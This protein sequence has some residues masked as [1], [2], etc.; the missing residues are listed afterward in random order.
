VGVAVVAADLAA[1]EVVA[2]GSAAASVVLE[3]TVDVVE[4]MAGLAT[5]LEEGD[6]VAAT[7]AVLED[8]SPIEHDH[9]FDS[10]ARRVC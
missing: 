7:E 1:H 10:G 5:C 8:S 9:E 6:I 2:E 3:G 4:A